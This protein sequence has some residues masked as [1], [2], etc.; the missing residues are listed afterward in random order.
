MSVG[1]NERRGAGSVDREKG[2]C[3]DMSG[4]GKGGMREG[5]DGVKEGEVLVCK[6]L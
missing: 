1:L 2:K 3:G 4:A 5:I 6:W